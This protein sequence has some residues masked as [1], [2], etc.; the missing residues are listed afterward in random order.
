MPVGSIRGQRCKLGEHGPTRP[1]ERA[2]EDEQ[3]CSPVEF[4]ERPRP[5]FGIGEFE[6]GRRRTDGQPLGGAMGL[7]AA[8]PT[9][10]GIE[11]KEDSTIL[12]EEL[13]GKPPAHKH[14]QPYRDQEPE[15]ATP[16][17]GGEEPDG[18]PRS[19]RTGSG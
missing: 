14:A 10:H 19:L 5:A 15:H 17:P 13:V 3:Y 2:E 7:I 12:L 18:C 16:F 11:S 1:A 4:R 8:H 6:A 9:L